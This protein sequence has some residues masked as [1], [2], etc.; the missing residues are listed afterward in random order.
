MDRPLRLQEVEAPGI[1]RQSVDE[2]SKVVCP[3]QRPTSY[4]TFLDLFLIFGSFK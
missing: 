4:N 2:N 1:S 3:A